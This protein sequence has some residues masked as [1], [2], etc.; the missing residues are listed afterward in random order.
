VYKKIGALIY[1]AATDAQSLKDLQDN[2]A[3][4]LTAAGV[5][6]SSIQGKK[7]DVIRDDPSLLNITVPEVKARGEFATP[8]DFDQ[9]LLEI[10]FVTIRAC[11]G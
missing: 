10:G 6:P 1:N 7:L 9:Y 8:A 2:A 3:G 5:P 11:K 4:M